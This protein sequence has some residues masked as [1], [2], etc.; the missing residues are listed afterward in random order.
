MTAREELILENSI[1]SWIPPVNRDNVKRWVWN[2]HTY[3]RDGYYNVWL[4]NEDKCGNYAGTFTG[5][6]IAPQFDGHI[7]NN[8]EH[9]EEFDATWTAY[10][11][12]IAKNLK[13]RK[14]LEKDLASIFM[15]NNSI[16]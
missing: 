7:R 3:F 4:I 10:R 14:E 15:P 1:T 2:C 8:E 13:T 16:K 11:K 5:D 6:R 9:E 12:Q